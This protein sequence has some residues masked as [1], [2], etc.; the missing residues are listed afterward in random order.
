MCRKPEPKSVR[1]N[2][3]AGTGVEIEWLD[4]H[5][6][7]YTFSY[8]RSVCPCAACSTRRAAEGRQPGGPRPMRPDDLGALGARASP[9]KVEPVGK[10]ALRFSWGDG[11][12]EGDYTWEFL[13]DVCPCPSC[14]A[15]W[16]G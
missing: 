12:R 16:R 14:S 6:S 1:V 13:R 10:Y 9:S 8:L 15:E 5:S 7:R 11:H 4:G 2:V 3:S